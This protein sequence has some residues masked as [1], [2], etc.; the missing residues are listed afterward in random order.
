M[1]IDVLFWLFAFPAAWVYHSS[2]TWILKD[3]N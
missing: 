1:T 2:F 3:F